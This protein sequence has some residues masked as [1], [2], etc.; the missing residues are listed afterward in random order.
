MASLA[1]LLDYDQRKKQ[2]LSALQAG[3]DVINRGTIAGT[4]GT[5]VDL[6]NTALQAV[7]LGSDKPVLGSEWIGD[8]MQQAGMVS[9]ERRPVAEFA[10]GFVNPETAATKGVMLAKALASKS[11]GLLPVAGSL[12]KAEK[13]IAKQASKSKALSGALSNPEY[14]VPHET[15]EF[16]AWSNNAPLITSEAAT[17]HPFKSGEPVS[18]EAYHGTKRPDRIGDR[19]LAKRAT[20]GPMAFHT[21]DPELASG[22]ATGKQDTSLAYEDTNYD[23][24]F[25]IP[26]AGSRKPV[27][28]NQ[29]WHS[30]TPEEKQK[31]AALAPRVG[32]SDDATEIVLH[33]EGHLSGI[34]NYDWEIKQTKGRFDQLGNPLKAL[35]ESWLNSGG[36]YN[37]EGR[38]M[39]VLKKAGVPTDKV[40]FDNPHA[41][42]P[43]VYKNYIKMQKPLVTTDIPPEVEQALNEAAKRDR[44]RPT[45]GASDMWDKKNRTL[46]EWVESFNQPDRAYVWTSIPD[47]VTD[48]FRSLGYDGIIDYSGKSGT[49]SVRPVYIPFGEDQLKSAIGNKGKFDPAKKSLTLGLA[50]P[51]IGGAMLMGNK[52]QDTY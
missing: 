4:L 6:A 20:S 29:A 26:V 8:K 1:E 39:E 49:G 22:Y 46:R 47:K 13:E 48:V 32:F 28:L 19:F 35:T 16:K 42:M 50:A 38:F 24:W 9:P 27:N 43:F 15:S 17:T 44:S 2:M 14:V 5:P 25:K 36:L 52:D 45:R 7:G 37:D 18:L 31:I 12:V 23:T 11:A 10:A 21:S 40:I 3:T 34:G 41:E 33:P 51:V 30:F